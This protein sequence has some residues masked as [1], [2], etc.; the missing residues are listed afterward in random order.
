MK[1]FIVAL[2]VVGVLIPS[3]SLAAHKKVKVRK[4]I[5]QKVELKLK[6]WNICNGRCFNVNRAEA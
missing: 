2:L 6:E 5:L 1:K 3:V 4:S